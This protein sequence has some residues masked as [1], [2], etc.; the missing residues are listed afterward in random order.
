[1]K[2]EDNEEEDVPEIHFPALGDGEGEEL[3]PSLETGF[4]MLQSLEQEAQSQ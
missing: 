3:Q 1:M 2:T 4:Q